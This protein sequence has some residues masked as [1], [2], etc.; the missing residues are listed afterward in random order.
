MTYG[1]TPEGFVA[2][3]S[4]TILSEIEADQRADIDPTLD[5]SAESVVGM[6]NA[7][8]VKKLTEVW[9]QLGISYTTRRP[10]DAKHEQLDAVCAITGTARAPATKG[11]VRLTLSV[12][13]GR[14][15]PAG[16]I[17]QVVGQPANRWITTEAA[18]NSAGGT[19]ANKI[20]AAIAETAGPIVANAGTITTIATPISGWLSVTNE[21][22][23]EV[24]KPAD[25]DPQLRTRRETELSKPGT[26]TVEAIRAD[27]LA[28]RFPLNGLCPFASV[29]VEENA[30]AWPD[31]FGRP[32]NT[33]EVV[34]QLAAWTD[35]LPSDQ[36]LNVIAMISKQFWL[37]K[38]GGIEY[39]GEEEGG[40]L[41]TVDSMGITREMAISGAALAP[42]HGDMLLSIDPAQFSE[43]AVLDAITEFGSA[44]VMGS[45]VIRS[46]LL[47]A[48]VD[49]PGVLDVAE[50]T[51]GRASTALYATNIAIGRREL[52]TFDTANFTVRTS[53]SLTS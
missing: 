41:I 27:L 7:I 35:A 38:P 20:V 25:G 12:A 36:Q 47:C 51:I 8:M 32:P 3:P 2:K 14:V 6:I 30:S 42:I 9:E 53:P 24:G 17:A 43:Q 33:I 10:R 50:L 34:V 37:S 11:S 26:G 48:L 1:L 18:D 40:S 19:T 5:T 4:E 23:A 49:V 39:Y 45:D 29:V 21:R 13:A 22:D 46:R 52:A 28:L 15:I 16:A 44:M 31:A